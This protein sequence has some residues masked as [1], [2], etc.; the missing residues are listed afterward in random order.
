M[1]DIFTASETTTV[2]TAEPATPDNITLPQLEEE[3]KYH[4]NQ[5]SQN[6]IEIGKRLIQAKS[7]VKHGQWQPWLND[8]FHL[9]KSTAYNFMQCAERYGNFQSIGNLNST[10]MIALLSLLDAEETEKFIEQKAAAGTPVSD[11]SVKTLRNEIKQWNAA[12]KQITSLKSAEDEDVETI[13]VMPHTF[14]QKQDKSVSPVPNEQETISPG[15]IESPEQSF[16]DFQQPYPETQSRVDETPR[17]HDDEGSALLEPLIELPGT[18]LIDD[19]LSYCDSLI[20]HENRDEIIKR[21]V[22]SNPDRIEPGIQNLTALISEL[23]AA[24]KN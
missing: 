19:I 18:Y 9:S 20:R 2:T 15:N 3:I 14:P 13:A 1:E 7:L 21:F 24:R 4:L 22:Q 23:Q 17:T 8:N 6:I 16:N 5:I 10:Q 12:K 11:M